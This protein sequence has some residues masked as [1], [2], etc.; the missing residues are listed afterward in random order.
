MDY[1][2]FSAEF[3]Q[4]E[5]IKNLEAAFKYIC[6]SQETEMSEGISQATWISILHS[7]GKSYGGEADLIRAGNL[8]FESIDLNNSGKLEKDE[9]MDA[10]IKAIMSHVVK[11]PLGEGCHWR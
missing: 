2:T 7:L 6:L 3:I 1:K 9:F 5:E 10:C 4:E 8:I 11:I